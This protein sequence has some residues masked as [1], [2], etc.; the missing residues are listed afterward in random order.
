MSAAGF[1]RGNFSIRRAI[2]KARLRYPRRWFTL[3]A[4]ST[5]FVGEEHVDLPRRNLQEPKAPELRTDDVLPDAALARAG[6]R[7]LQ[8][9]LDPPLHELVDSSPTLR[10]IHLVEPEALAIEPALEVGHEPFR[11]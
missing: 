5:V 2:V 11:L 7:P 6:R 1:G 10:Q 4:L 9:L 8:E 3:L